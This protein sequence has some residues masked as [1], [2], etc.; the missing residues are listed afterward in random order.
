[1]TV[2]VVIEEDRHYDTSVRVYTNY[3]LAMHYSKARARQLAE[4]YQE[5]EEAEG[6]KLTT[7]MRNAGWIY[8]ATTGDD[9]AK[10]RLVRTIT[11]ESAP[12]GIGG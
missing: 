6:D 1:M 5:L 2:F 4:R 12:G 3:G 10:L 11:Q 7:D 8:H 9:G